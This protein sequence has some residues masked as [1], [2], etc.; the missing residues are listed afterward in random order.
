MELRETRAREA[1]VEPFAYA[2]A[3][4]PLVELE[5]HRMCKP[6]IAL[7]NGAAVGGGFG[8][9]LACDMRIGS[10][11]ARFRVA[12][13]KIGLNVADAT[14]WMLPRIIGIPNA[15][16]LI[17]TGDMVE[18]EEAHSIGLL[19]KVVPPD[20]LEEEGMALARKIAQGPP[21]AIRYDKI[22][23]Y[24]SLKSDLETSISYV[25][26]GERLTM[27]SEDFVEGMNAFAEKREPMFRGK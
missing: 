21:I 25:H 19:D 12:F 13:T 20:R 22:M 10:E 1:A 18:A 7:V 23:L 5:L 17:F 24:R 9:A 6:T 15:C 4:F 26:L 16:R 2:G 8:L 11:K 14:M 27:A 3:G